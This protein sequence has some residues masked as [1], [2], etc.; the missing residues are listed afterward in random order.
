MLQLKRNTLNM[1]KYIE[2]DVKHHIKKSIKLHVDG[3]AVIR[4]TL[5]NPL[6]DYHWM[7]VCTPTVNK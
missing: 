7:H 3:I 6:N 5:I 4:N 1:T 2:Y